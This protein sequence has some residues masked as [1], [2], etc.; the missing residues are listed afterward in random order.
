[1]DPK[2]HVIMQSSGGRSYQRRPKRVTA[3]LRVVVMRI[4]E[5]EVDGGINGEI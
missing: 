5:R 4:E 1:M 3:N 2:W